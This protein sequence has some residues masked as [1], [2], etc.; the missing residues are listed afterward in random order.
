MNDG[1]VQAARMHDGLVQ[2]T[3]LEGRADNRELLRGAG[4]LRVLNNVSVRSLSIIVLDRLTTS[5]WGEYV[6]DLEGNGRSQR[7]RSDESQQ[8][9]GDL[10]FDGGLVAGEDLLTSN[11]V[12]VRHR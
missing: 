12:C 4:G 3:R 8:D 1:L 7:R 9:S 6:L 5:K 10:H 11:V 2:A